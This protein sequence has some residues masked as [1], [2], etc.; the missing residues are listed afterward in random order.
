MA[1]DHVISSGISIRPAALDDAGALAALSTQLGYPTSED[2]ARRR[3]TPILENPENVLYVAAT[4]GGRVIGW[5]HAY[6]C[7]LVESDLNAEIGGLVVDQQDRRSG[8]G[9]LLMQYAEHWARSKNCKTVNLRSNIIR[10][11]AHA[12]YLHL[13]YEIVKT[14]HAFRKFL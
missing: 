13:G 11:G 5:L 4:P 9:R 7:R 8:A 1:T 12:F 14:Q 10:E 2:E 3:L 6:L